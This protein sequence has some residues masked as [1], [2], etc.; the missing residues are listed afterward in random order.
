MPKANPTNEEIADLLEEV[1]DLLEL[2]DA[3]DF[4]IR[5]F[6]KAAVNVRTL[7]ESVA[8]HV[9][10]EGDEV[11]RSIPGVGESISR[12]ILEFLRTGR[13]SFL[14][15][16]RRETQPA[17]VF[18]QVPGVGKALAERVAD[19][20]DVSTLEGLEQAAHDGRLETVEGFG[21]ERVRN[22]VRIALAGLLRRP[23]RRIDA[24]RS[25][26]D[27]P[28]VE[29]LLDVD[30]EYRR[31]AQASE[32][33]KIAPKRFNPDG[34]RWLPI[35][36]TRRGPSS[37]T[38]LFS[39]TARAHDVG[40]TDDWVVVY[41]ERDGAED[42]V[43]VVTETRGDLEGMRVVRGRERECR[44]HYASIGGLDEPAS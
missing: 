9:D 11:V 26:V 14:N 37:F 24:Q 8:V 18:R 22:N 3:D 40:K 35:L 34:S 31:K 44:R 12:V 7:E 29:T 32:L 17:D 19:R 27:M 4:R 30:E 6:R 16:L 20:L 25:K 39:N 36:K 42:Q 15:R 10:R 5:A 2:Q 1:A 33:R 13:S 43:T 21:E 23:R 41:Y 28:D 38:A